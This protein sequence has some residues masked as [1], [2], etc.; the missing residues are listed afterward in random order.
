MEPQNRSANIP[1]MYSS[2]IIPIYPTIPPELLCRQKTPPRGFLTQFTFRPIMHRYFFHF[3]YKATWNGENRSANILTSP[4]FPNTPQ[5]NRKCCARKNPRPV[6]SQSNLHFSSI[7]N[8]LFFNFNFKTTWNPKIGRRISR[9]CIQVVSFPNTSQ[10]HRNCC[11]GKTPPRGF[12]T[13]LH[14]SPIMHRYFFISLIRRHGTAKSVGEY[15]NVAII[16]NNPQFNRNVVQAKTPPRG[17]L[18]QFTFQSYHA[19]LFFTSL[20]RRHGTAKIG[21]RIS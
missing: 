2:R 6:A 8:R 7:M 18:T 10:F 19:P 12:L 11:A 17:F 15:L 21:R 1:V 20:I 16:P 4:L 9:W 5:F 14:F 13:Q 3:T